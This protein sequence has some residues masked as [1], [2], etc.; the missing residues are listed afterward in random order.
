MSKKIR[1]H[2]GVARK[3]TRLKRNRPI[4]WRDVLLP[5]VLCLRV[6]MR[7]APKPLKML[8]TSQSPRDAWRIGA[9]PISPGTNSKPRWKPRRKRREISHRVRFG[10]GTRIEKA[11]GGCARKNH[12]DHRRSG[13]QSAPDTFR[14]NAGERRLL[15]NPFRKLPG[16]L[17]HRKKQTGRRNR[18]GRA[19][20]R[21]L[22]KTK[23]KPAR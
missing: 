16:C 4:M 23:I 19:S 11:A 3:L 7:R 17:R 8:R 1:M 22:Q 6:A 9:R 12:S 20:P 13:R 14:K 5:L 15:Q 2:R 10:G 21:G 18:A